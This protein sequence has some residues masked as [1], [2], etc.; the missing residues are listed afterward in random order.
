MHLFASHRVTKRKLKACLSVRPA[1]GLRDGVS[2]VV[3]NVLDL[4]SPCAV[5]DVKVSDCLVA[6]N[7]NSEMHIPLLCDKFLMSQQPALKYTWNTLVTSSFWDM[8]LS[9]ACAATDASTEFQNRIILYNST[10]SPS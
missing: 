9:I 4:Y 8:R 5:I 2:L 1:D 3:E 6:V 10:I 7:G